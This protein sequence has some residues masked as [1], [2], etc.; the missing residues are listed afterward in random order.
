M[1]EPLIQFRCVNK[2]YR[3]GRIEAHVLRDVDLEVEQGDYVAVVG[4]SGSGKSTLLNII[5]GLDGDYSGRAS[6]PGMILLS[7]AM[8]S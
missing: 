1:H 5:G 2:H 7:S 6:V 4:T 8:P 3:S